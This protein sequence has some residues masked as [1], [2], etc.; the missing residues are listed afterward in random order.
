MLP[1]RA[2]NTRCP[3]DKKR[4]VR[5]AGR[6]FGTMIGRL[7]AIGVAGAI[8]RADKPDYGQDQSGERIATHAV[9]VRRDLAGAAWSGARQKG[10]LKRRR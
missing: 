2:D 4:A 8:G 1:E 10:S 7:P 5:N 9:A 3:G 6:I